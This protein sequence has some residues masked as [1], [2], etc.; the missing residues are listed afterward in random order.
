MDWATDV[1]QIP[2]AADGCKKTEDPSTGE[3]FQPCSLL[4]LVKVVPKGSPPAPRDS[5]LLRVGMATMSPTGRQA[6]SEGV[7]CS[8]RRRPLEAAMG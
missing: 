6:S 3:Q 8:W 4:L 5:L 1:G 2:G 7:T